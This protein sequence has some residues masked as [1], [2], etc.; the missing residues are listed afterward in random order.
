MITDWMQAIVGA[1]TSVSQGYSQSTIKVL[2]TSRPNGSFLDVSSGVPTLEI[3]ETDAASDVRT[4]IYS[5]VEQFARNRRPRDDVAYT[6]AQFLEKNAQGMFLWVVLIMKELERRDERLT[7]EI[8]MEKLSSISLTIMESYTTIV[9]APVSS[10]RKDMWKIMRWLLYG[11]R[12]MTLDDLETGLCLEDGTQSWHGFAGDLEYLCGTLIR[13]DNPEARVRLVHQTARSFLKTYVRNSSPEDVSGVFMDAY[14][15]HEELAIVCIRRLSRKEEFAKLERYLV[16][17]RTQ[18]DYIDTIE[19]FLC[20]HPFYRYGIEGWTHHIRGAMPLSQRLKTIVRDL[21]SCPES[22]TN[23]LRLTYY[24]FK[25]GSAAIP[26][27]NEPIHIAAYFNLPELLEQYISEDSDSV[28]AMGDADDAPL[29]WASEMDSLE[30][31]R[32][33]LRAGADPNDVEYDGWSPLHRV[34][35]N[36]HAAIAELLLMH[37]ARV[38]QRDSKGHTPMDWAL[39]REHTSVIDVLRRWGP[40]IHVDSA[41]LDRS[42]PY[43]RNPDHLMVLRTLGSF[44]TIGLEMHK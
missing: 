15:A 30:C 27:V 43:T 7:D 3:G 20:E 9:E 39:D 4:L 44:G 29:I 37:G 26:V 21:L 22:R 24:L 42:K 34:A 14:S 13:L 12:D 2:A 19:G 28:N 8:I 1:P 33:L 16:L 11:C 31:V 36:D 17:L 38:D 41:Q 6:I 40:S 10:R 35:R 18:E 23:L 25:H 5:R 32:L